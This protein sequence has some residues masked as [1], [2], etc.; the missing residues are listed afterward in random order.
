MFGAWINL[1]GTG[2]TSYSL[3]AVDCMILGIDGSKLLETLGCH[4]FYGYKIL[5]HV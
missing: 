5:N 4:P 1:A 2:S 3:E